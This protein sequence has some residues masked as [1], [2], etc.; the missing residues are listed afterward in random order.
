MALPFP[1]M[2]YDAPGTVASTTTIGDLTNSQ[3]TSTSSTLNITSGGGAALEINTKVEV[4]TNAL[5]LNSSGIEAD[6]GGLKI[7]NIRG[8]AHG[9]GVGVM[10]FNT[11]T[12][13]ITYSTN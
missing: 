6:S 4:K 9:L 11:S 8:V 5:K 10:H 2:E 3:V 1:T 13:E 12:N 7:S